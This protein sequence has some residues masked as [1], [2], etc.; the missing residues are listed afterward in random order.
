MNLQ[1]STAIALCSVVEAA[2]DPGRQISSAD[3]AEKYRVSPHHLAK[4][5]RRLGR[6]GLLESTR[7]VGGGYRFSGNAKRLTLMDI[8]DLFEDMIVEPGE[9]SEREYSTGVEQ[10]IAQ[11]LIEID[12]TAKA[13][14][15]SITIAT[16]LGLIERQNGAVDRKL[17]AG[18][19]ET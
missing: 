16:M 1:K 19:S 9:H 11:V 18:S 6:A 3:I 5:L 14:F 15:K 12:E 13:V 17:P 10:A 2:R 8:I 7:G 4:V